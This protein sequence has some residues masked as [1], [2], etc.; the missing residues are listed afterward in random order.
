[1]QVY[2]RIDQPQA[3]LKEYS[4]VAQSQAGQI[5]MLLGQA[6]IHDAMNDLDSGVTLYKEV[7]AQTCTV[8]CSV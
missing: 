8:F 4:R 3:A 1:M 2:T 5:E 6:R 7:C